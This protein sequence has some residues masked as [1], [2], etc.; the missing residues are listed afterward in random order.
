MANQE[1]TLKP[2]RKEGRKAKSRWVLKVIGNVKMGEKMIYEL[3][4]SINNIYNS[5]YFFPLE[6]NYIVYYKVWDIWFSLKGVMSVA[7]YLSQAQGFVLRLKKKKKSHHNLKNKT[8]TSDEQYYSSGSFLWSFS[9]HLLQC[10]ANLTIFLADSFQSMRKS[11]WKAINFMIWQTFLSP[12]LFTEIPVVLWFSSPIAF[13]FM[14]PSGCIQ[15]L[16]QVEAMEG[17][18]SSQQN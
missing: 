18:T 17:P 2:K 14:G 10:Y 7:W 12:V 6:A 1:E 11:F 5:R 4:S 9:S 13:Y 3:K 15:T 16:R 8:N